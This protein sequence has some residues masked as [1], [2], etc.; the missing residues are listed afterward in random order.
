MS[1]TRRDI[2]K[3]IAALG[4]VGALPQRREASEAPSAVPARTCNLIVDM[5]DPATGRETMTTMQIRIDPINGDAAIGYVH[6]A[7]HSLMTRRYIDDPAVVAFLNELL[8]TPFALQDE[9]LVKPQEERDAMHLA[10]RTEEWNTSLASRGLTVADLQ[11][12]TNR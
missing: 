1:P 4:V 9:Y 6:S 7:D 11:E 12:G 3:S 5:F 8:D 10:R 2:L